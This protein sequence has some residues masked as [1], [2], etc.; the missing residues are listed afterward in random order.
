MS[1]SL[2]PSPSLDIPGL[3]RGPDERLAGPG[4][5]SSRPNRSLGGIVKVAEV[6]AHFQRRGGRWAELQGLHPAGA[7][8]WVRNRAGVERDS[9]LLKRFS[10]LDL[11][12]DSPNSLVWNY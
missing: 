12:E 10:L 1:L 4:A 7:E 8:S 3:R 9:V 6:A 5:R 11:H 2:H